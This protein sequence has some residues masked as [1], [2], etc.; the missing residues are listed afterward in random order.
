MFKD[1]RNV[2]NKIRTA[3]SWEKMRDKKC[4]DFYFYKVLYLLYTGSLFRKLFQLEIDE[5]FDTQ[6]TVPNLY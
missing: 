1:P 6:K 5:N 2:E 3:P 4:G